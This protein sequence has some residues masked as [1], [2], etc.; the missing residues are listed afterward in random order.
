[1][2]GL[3]GVA[4]RTLSCLELES[5]GDEAESESVASTLSADSSRSFDSS[6]ISSDGLSSIDVSGFLEGSLVGAEG[7][8]M[9]GGCQFVMF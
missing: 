2:D 7:I 6:G 4:G 9:V 8:G 3:G 5:L 1:M